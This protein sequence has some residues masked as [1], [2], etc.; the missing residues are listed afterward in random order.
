M[1]A[2]PP[3][4]ERPGPSGARPSS[5]AGTDRPGRQARAMPP[6]RP[7]FGTPHR[8]VAGV[9]LVIAVALVPWIVF[10]GVTLP[11]RYEA[12]HWPL[13][14]IGYDVAE[15]AV[16]LVAA[17]AA[18]FRRQILAATSLVAATL[19]LCD[20]WFDVVSSF[21]HRDQWVTLATAIGGEIPLA[22][23]F[24]W[25]YHSIVMRSLIAYH[26]AVHDGERPTSIV[27]ARL[28]ISLDDDPVDTLA[29]RDAPGGD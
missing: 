10:L 25:L 1:Q 28:L 4:E 29:R 27:G 2:V 9:I 20:A 12:G 22:V 8:V 13:L 26:E 24:L 21:G 19:M 14:W 3:P 5:G 18:W 7:R 15:V 16:L 11:P 23:F 17:W 6:P